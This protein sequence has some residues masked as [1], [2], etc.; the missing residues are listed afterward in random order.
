MLTKKQLLITGIS[1]AF[2]LL[3]I[4]LGLFFIALNNSDNT[5]KEL[6]LAS[7]DQKHA[8]YRV[9]VLGVD[10]F[11]NLELHNQQ[12]KVI[13]EISE[14][15]EG[16]V[17]R[18]VPLMWLDN[19]RILLYENQHGIETVSTILK[20]RDYLKHT[21]VFNITTSPRIPCLGFNLE[22]WQ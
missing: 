3:I 18:W 1:I 9:S 2:L 17:Y 10:H 14:S 8:I 5:E 22:D 11:H 16:D 21:L 7:P 6:L 12:G 19:H 13:K 15:C 4:S 20:R